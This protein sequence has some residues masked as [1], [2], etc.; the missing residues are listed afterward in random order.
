VKAAVWHGPRD[1]RVE[2]IAEPAPG[3]GEVLVEVARNGLCGSDLHTYVGSGAA[4]VHV[5]GVVLGHE[6]A[7]TVR[8][9]GSGVDDLALGD[10]VAVA[11]IEW[12]G[13]CPACRRGT[14]NL[15]RE[16]ALYGGYRLPLHGGLAPLVAVSRRSA[17]PV[18]EGLDVVEAALAEPTAVAVHAVRRAPQ[19]FGASVVVLG[20]G[21][22][23][24]AVL[25]SV[26][27]A[28]AA[29]TIVS[30][31]SSA[32][33]ALARR[34]GD[35]VSID[36]NDDDL[37]G[38]VRDLTADGADLVFDTAGV[39]A[40]FDVGLASLRPRGAMVVVAQWQDPARLDV[41]RVLSKEIELGF[42]FTYEPSVDFP[43]ALGLLASGHVDA[44]AMI[45]D[46]IAL[47]DVVE[48]GLEELLHHNDRHV[49]ILVDP[50]DD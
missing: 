12:C 34:F 28:G 16:L 44:S 43:I 7:G 25:Q 45:S 18:P 38:A 41:G 36:P 50:H 42:A 10:A 1:L 33:R 48:Q 21:P 19:T 46:H 24:L 39:Q 31:P 3:P 30:E 47:D 40:A 49:K 8:A 17:F 20:A 9:L 13:T 15:C 32:R 22:I 23:G 29:A 35:T 11:P 26:V 6:F 14:P 5:P 37:R 4:A 2:E 27:A